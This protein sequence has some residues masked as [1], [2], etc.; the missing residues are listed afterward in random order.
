MTREV[1]ELAVNEYVQG[2]TERDG[3]VG[4]AV[5]NMTRAV[6]A[7]ER[8]LRASEEDPSSDEASDETA[9][10]WAGV[11]RARGDLARAR[12]RGKWAARMAPR[13]DPTAR[14]LKDR[15]EKAKA[16]EAARKADIDRLKALRV[17]VLW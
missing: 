16:D 10:R 11:V 7:F 17:R 9:V 4:P 13:N 12:E 5:D 6:E 14:E 1:A 3:R 8:S 15:V 2:V